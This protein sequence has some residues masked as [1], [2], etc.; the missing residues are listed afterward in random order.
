[1]T[2]K[3]LVELGLDQR[4][5]APSPTESAKFRM[6]DARVLGYGEVRTERKLLKNAANPD[7]FRGADAVIRG[8][9]ALD[10]DAAAARGH[11]AREHIHQSRLAGPVI[12]DQ[13]HG[14]AGDKREIDTGQRLHDTETFGNRFQPNDLAIHLAA[15]I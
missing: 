6:R 11:R 10:D 15:S 13:A 7:R 9:I 3:N 4:S 12:S 5:R 2:G 14:L 1:M 8:C